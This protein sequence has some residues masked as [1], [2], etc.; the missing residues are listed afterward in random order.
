[1][2]G[3]RGG[4]FF[5]YSF[6][7]AHQPAATFGNPLVFATFLA[8]AAPL[9]LGLQRIWA[10]AIFTVIVGLLLAMEGGRTAAL[11]SLCSATI[12]YAFLMRKRR[13]GGLLVLGLLIGCGIFKGEL[14]D[15][16]GR[17]AGWSSLTQRWLSID[18]VFGLGLGA[19]RALFLKENWLWYPLHNDLL[20]LFVETGLVGGG[21]FCCTLFLAVRSALRNVTP[22]KA[23]WLAAGVAYLLMSL[24]A[25]PSDIGGTLAIGCLVIAQNG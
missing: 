3:K 19:I 8:I 2:W 13:L 18:P 15:F 9:L 6:P 25:F 20:A 24:C 1:M 12:C 11:I 21:L 23:G 4:L 5:V 22:L 7:V 14:A 10:K 17:L 16:G